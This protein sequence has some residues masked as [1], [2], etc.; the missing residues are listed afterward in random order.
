MKKATRK[1]KRN[2]KRVA[3]RIDPDEILPEYDFS[4]GERN[5]YAA[6]YAS[7][8]RVVELDPDVATAFPNSRAVNDALRALAGIIKAHTPQARRA[9]RKASKGQS[10]SS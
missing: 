1:P 6:R 9:T 2:G 4:K 3:P 5:R 7:T 8:G 10:A